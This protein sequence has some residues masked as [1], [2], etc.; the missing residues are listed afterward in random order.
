MHRMLIAVALMAGVVGACSGETAIVVEVNWYAGTLP[1]DAAQLHIYVGRVADGDPTQ[2]TVSADGSAVV[3]IDPIEPTYRYVLRPNGALADIGDLSIAAGIT[4]DGEPTTVFVFDEYDAPIAFAQDETRLIHL[5][6]VDR[7]V[8]ANGDCVLWGTG[9]TRVGA[10]IGH[11]GDRDCDGVLDNDD[12]DP[13]DPANTATTRDAD[14]DGAVCNDCFDGGAPAPVGGW[15][16]DPGSVFPGQNEEAFRSANNIPETVDCLHIDFDCSDT[17]GDEPE[18]AGDPRPALDADG[19]MADVCGSIDR[20]GGSIACRPH[21]SDC[22]EGLVPDNNP[23]M[24]DPEICD[25]RDSNCDGRPSPGLPCAVQAAP[26]GECTVGV[27][28]CIDDVGRYV[29]CVVNGFAPLGGPTVCAF[30]RGTESRYFFDDPLGSGVLPIPCQV[31]AP[32]DASCTEFERL[33]LGATP[34]ANC[35]WRVFGGVMQADWDIGFVAHGG[36]GAPQP[37]TSLCAPD[38][39]VRAV[40]GNPQTRTVFV[41]GRVSPTMTITKFLTLSADTSGGACDGMLSC[42]IN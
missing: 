28:D 4:N 12:C 30:L 8:I 3:S 39:V 35:E 27:T 29:G 38:L 31:A 16:V 17:C 18:Q 20:V 14:G 42:A 7:R 19:S 15:L 2:A 36:M 26:P 9:Q 13:L 21:P 41:A 6:L 33:T 40:N 11:S 32:A 1:T 23:T 22:V 25:G 37:T 5:E 24:G 34:G 10:S